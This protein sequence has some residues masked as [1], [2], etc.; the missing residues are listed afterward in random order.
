MIEIASRHG[1]LKALSAAIE[2]LKKEPLENKMHI[3]VLEG[4]RSQIERK[5]QNER[6]GSD[7]EAD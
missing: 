3:M 5:L 4:L 1:Y 2:V 6:T 7:S